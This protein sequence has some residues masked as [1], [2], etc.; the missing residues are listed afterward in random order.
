MVIV[1]GVNRQ[2]RHLVDGGKSM[3]SSERTKW[4]AAVIVAFILGGCWDRIHTPSE[5]GRADYDG[6]FSFDR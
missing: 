1:A 2:K 5:D 4:L 6:M 3:S